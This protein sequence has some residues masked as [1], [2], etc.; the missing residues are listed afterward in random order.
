M[1]I[2]IGKIKLRDAWIIISGVAFW[3]MM[4]P[5]S[6][7]GILGIPVSVVIMYQ[8]VKKKTWTRDYVRNQFHVSY[9]F[10]LALVYYVLITNFHKRWAMSGMVGTLAGVL[11]LQVSQFLMIVEVCAGILSLLFSILVCCILSEM[12]VIR[13]EEHKADLPKG[14][15]SLNA[16]DIVFCF[17]VSLCFSMLL[18]LNPWSGGY[19][20]SDSSVF[21]YI[22]RRMQ[23]GAIPYVD[24]FDHKGIVLYLLEWLGAVITPE[25]FTGMWMLEILNLFVLAVFVLLIA[26]LFSKNRVAI[27]LT[28][29]VAIFILEPYL[30]YEG[31]NLTE[32]YA[33]P[34]IAM[35]LYVFLKY[36]IH[37]SYSI[38]DIIL[39]GISFSVVF[40]LRVNMV[41]VWAAYMPI[42]FVGM[43]WKKQW[44]DLGKCVVGF[45]TG[46]AI[47]FGLLGTYMIATGCVDEMIRYYFQFNFG[48]SDSEGSALSVIRTMGF[49]LK[50]S[51]AY[52]IFELMAVKLFYK[53]KLL[54]MNIW[55]TVVSLGLAAMSGRPYYH[56]G[57]VLIPTL[58]V[59]T[60]M[61]L[62]KV[63]E[64]FSWKKERFVLGTVAVFFVIQLGVAIM[65]KT[66]ITNTEMVSFLINN[67]RKEDNVL[68]IGNDCRSY[69]QSDRF[70][71]NRF[72]YQTPP[73]NVSDE[74][75]VEFMEEVKQ[76][77]HDTI[78]VVGEYKSILMAENNLSDVCKM[79]DSWTEEGIYEFE[80]FESYF[81]YKLMINKE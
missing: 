68:V 20:G 38:W 73:I 24:L 31:G 42:V 56:Y 81:V 43:L 28:V 15:V 50:L 17:L 75:Y 55:F 62:T 46:C 27:Y 71:E 59:P 80:D 49:L 74:I 11:G 19:P 22:G 8:F 4:M 30:A 76:N 6:L 3:G 26:R 1:K 48:Y 5:A 33:L 36:F 39:L 14:C 34:W 66:C 2:S 52:V 16:I 72:F 29:I 47:V 37:E 12:K 53:N 44:K 35:A 54:Q 64:F 13:Q 61:V 78:L 70:T 57:I 60:V 32:E 9:V 79:L 65:G 21:L 45:L 77:F 18:A 7:F 41:T 58:I 40:F 69:L 67:T 51:M 63:V 25:S 23:Q 10:L